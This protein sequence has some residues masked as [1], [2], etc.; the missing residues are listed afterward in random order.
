MMIIFKDTDWLAVFWSVV[1]IT[2][3]ERGVSR[4]RLQ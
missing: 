4:V 1:D 3:G 2:R